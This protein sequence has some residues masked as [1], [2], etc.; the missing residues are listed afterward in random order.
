MNNTHPLCQLSEPL[1]LL[2]ASTSREVI[3]KSNL[4]QY[5]RDMLVIKSNM[6]HVLDYIKLLKNRLERL[7]SEKEDLIIK[8]KQADRE[9]AFLDGRYKV[10]TKSPKPKKEETQKFTKAE[11][12]QIIDALENMRKEKVK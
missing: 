2:P 5:K 11:L 10:I 4:E 7:N 12:L 6:S 1:R 9:L 8:Y 3:L